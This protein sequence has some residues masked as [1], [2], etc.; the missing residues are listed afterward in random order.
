M[1]YTKEKLNEIFYYIEEDNFKYNIVI[2]LAYIYG[3]NITEVL[4]LRK[5]DIN[6]EAME[7]LFTTNTENIIFPI[8]E[9]LQEPLTDYINNYRKFKNDDLL[10][11]DKN[12]RVETEVKKLNYYLDQT[13]TSL[14][15]ILE[16]NYPKLTTSDFKV[17][18]GQHLFLDGAELHVIN[19]LYHNKNI[20]S[21]RRYLDYDNL[22]KLKFP[23]TN[24]EELLEDYTDLEIYYDN[25]YQ[26]LELVTVID[27]TENIVI[28]LDY[29][30]NSVSVICNEEHPIS[31][32]VQLLD[33]EYLCTLLK[34][35]KPGYYRIINDLKFLKN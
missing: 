26:K 30:S 32:Q 25:S 35:L 7:I 22:L 13:I 6:L 28:E 17:L 9:T 5:K 33:P 20:T 29:P 21:T 8:I 14:N 31:Q 27:D 2:K 23:C 1:K 18:R 10:F 3:R 15:K 4:N 34:P 19:D 16:T 24:L 12:Y 11:R